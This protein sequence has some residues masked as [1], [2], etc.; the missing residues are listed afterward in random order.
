MTEDDLKNFKD[1]FTGY[2][3]SFLTGKGPA[4]GPILFK[5]DHTLRVCENMRMLGESEKLSTQEMLVAETAA[6]FHDVGRFRQY[7]EYGTFR[8]DLS[9]SHSRLGLSVLGH[10]R[11]LAPCGPEEKRRIAGAIAWHNA[12]AVPDTANG[13]RRKLMLLL[14]DADKLDIW[15][16][17]TDYYLRKRT[18]PDQTVELDLPDT[19]VCSAR[20]LE[21]LARGRMVR[22]KDLEGVNDFKLFQISWV[23]DL[24]F[25][26]SFRVL[27]DRGFIEAIAQT[28]PRT[29]TVRAAVRRALEYV[30]GN[31]S[32]SLK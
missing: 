3:Q 26:E 32:G 14:R 17:M 19:G 20:C 12:S 1:W 6:L 18:E 4:D 5:R 28:L 15:R 29:E 27:R 9:A 2:A 25:P 22:M 10:H 24:N 21:T 7:R 11:I 13:F 8:D 30:V 16:V 31:V 23:Y